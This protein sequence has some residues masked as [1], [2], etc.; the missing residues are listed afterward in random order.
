M[1]AAIINML[2]IMA[3]NEN[4]V[5]ADWQKAAKAMCYLTER[6]A[7]LTSPVDPS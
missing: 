3:T 7:T 6:L 4:T 1:L 2:D 5:E